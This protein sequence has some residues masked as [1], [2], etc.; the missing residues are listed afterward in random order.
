MYVRVK[1]LLVA[2][3]RI[4]VEGAGYVE[5]YLGTG[6]LKRIHTV[7]GMKLDYDVETA[8]SGLFASEIEL[9]LSRTLV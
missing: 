5:M 7:A 3:E 9:V 8:L 2:S 1:E 6:H 4:I